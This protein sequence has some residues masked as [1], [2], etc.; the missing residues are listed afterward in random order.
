M[1]REPEACPA[2]G[3]DEF[4]RL[5][6]AVKAD[7]EAVGF[8]NAVDVPEGRIDPVSLAIVADGLAVARTIIAEIGRV[9]QDEIDRLIRDPAHDVGAVAVKDAVRGHWAPPFRGR[10]CSV[11]AAL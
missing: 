10:R 3:A 4:V 7:A 1:S 5:V 2:P 11:R 8:H 9:G 6:P